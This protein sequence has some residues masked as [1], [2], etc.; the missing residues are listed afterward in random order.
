MGM[1]A[2]IKPVYLVAGFGL[3]ATSYFFRALRFK[4]LIR[5]KNMKFYDLFKIVSI[6]N[7]VNNLLPMRLGEF[8][9]IYLIKKH[10]ITLMEG[11]ES[12][13][14]SRV[15]DI[16]SISLFFLISVYGLADRIGIS[17]QMIN[18]IV[19]VWFVVF[20]SSMLIQFNRKPILLVCSFLFK[21]IKKF[22]NSKLNKFGF[23]IMSE[24]QTISEKPFS[25]YI[26]GNSFITSLILGINLYSLNYILINFGLNIHLSILEVVFISTFPVFSSL[27]PIQGLSG[28][29]T[30]EGAWVLGFYLLG[31]PLNIAIITG[32]SMHI[33]TILY[34]TLLGGFTLF[35]Q[36]RGI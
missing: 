16:I 13:L 28:F 1:I 34:F 19:I 33:V 8:S 17:S 12:L 14:I 30:T 4:L 31:L 22:K 2:G 26:F 6:H 18:L 15:L 11:I 29:G 32:F 7:M 3:Y 23:S 5:S 36:N 25:N 35:A 21:I 10:K 27:L 9:Y 20:I 24:I